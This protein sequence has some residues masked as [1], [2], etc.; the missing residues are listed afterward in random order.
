MS[1]ARVRPN[2][3]VGEKDDEYYES[4]PCHSHHAGASE[5][6]RSLRLDAGDGSDSGD[7]DREAEPHEPSHESI[8][9]ERLR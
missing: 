1:T 4:E 6:L 7:D 2:S 3:E 5:V 9:Q 8:L